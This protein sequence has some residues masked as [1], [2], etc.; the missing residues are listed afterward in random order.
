MLIETFVD[1]L[2]VWRDFFDIC[3]IFSCN[4]YDFINLNSVF[5]S[6]R[7]LRSF[8]IFIY[9]LSFSNI[10][11]MT[12]E[13]QTDK[14]SFTLLIVNWKYNYFYLDIYSNNNYFYYKSPDSF[15]IS[16]AT[17]KSLFKCDCILIRSSKCVYKLLKSI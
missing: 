6:L 14:L 3:D 11:S 13:L 9:K 4:D 10:S 16:L 5:K 15:L 2:F 7:I 12:E 17:F 8:N 1:S